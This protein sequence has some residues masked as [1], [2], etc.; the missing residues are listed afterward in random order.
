M[1]A[2]QLVALIFPSAASSAIAPET[3]GD[4]AKSSAHRI[5]RDV[6]AVEAL[7]GT[8][9]MIDRA[10]QL[11]KAGRWTMVKVTN[12]PE[13]SKLDVPAVGTTTI[14]KLYAAGAG[15]LVLE[16]NKTIILERTK[17]LE[18]ADRYKIAVVG[19]DPG[20]PDMLPPEAREGG[21]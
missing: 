10:G 1:I 17:T 18:L 21:Q 8:N 20:R 4:I 11:C 5:N 15:C 3:A 19:F 7:E 14:E 2:M 9:A 13:D 12:G 16:A 6:I